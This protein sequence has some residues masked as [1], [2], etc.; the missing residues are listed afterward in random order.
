MLAVCYSVC[1]CVA[2]CLFLLCGCM[3]FC[4]FLAVCY[5]V[6]FCCVIAVAVRVA[7]VRLS[8]RARWSAGSG[9]CETD[10]V[11]ND[12]GDSRA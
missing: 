11:H 10:P 5:S 12:G 1:C 2:V 8:E 3:L 4:C 7:P 6:V 9:G